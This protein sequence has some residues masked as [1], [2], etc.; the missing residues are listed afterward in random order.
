M[1]A[2]ARRN[3]GSS[4]PFRTRGQHRSELTIDTPAPRTRSPLKSPSRSEVVPRRAVRNG[5][6][7]RARSASAASQLDYPLIAVLATL[8]ALG[9]VMVYSASMVRA[10]ATFGQPAYF[11]VR[12]II[13]AGAGM[14]A[15]LVMSRIPYYLWQRMAIPVMAL[16]LLALV[17]V[18]IFGVER[19][20][21][22][23]TLLNGSL[24]PSEFV[25]LAI[26]IYVAAWVAS[27]KDRL[28]EVQ[29][30]LIPFAALMG[31]VVGL[32]VLE[33]SFSVSIIILAT[34]ITIFFVGGGNVKQ[35]MLT[36][37]IGAAVLA[38]LVWQSG[39]GAHRVQTWWATLA[40]PS[41]ASYDVSQAM[42]IIRE[43]RGIGTD[44]SNWMQKASVPL[45]WSDYLFANVGA[46][47]GFIGTLSVIVLFAAL[48]YR[49]LSIALNAPDQFAGLTAIGIT[50][51]MLTQALIHISA[52][53]A[54]IPTTGVPLPF[55]SYG[56]S[57][58]LA[59]MAALGMLL[60]ISRASPEKR[61][62]YA[63]FTFG[64]WHR[65]PHLP[66]SRGGQRPEELQR[67]SD[68]AASRG[69]ALRRRTW[70]H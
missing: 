65:R 57:S 40:D 39:Y 53:L 20:G 24:Q 14:G 61:A 51:W 28:V 27:K 17:S 25:K 64:W 13:W 16:A 59:N 19:Y 6:Q 52:S 68:R 29:G 3:T 1:N 58:M 36:G 9:L 10:Q 55:M 35:L 33:R 45:L 21:A 48:G 15:L 70:R 18:L 11:F 23:R 4:A 49:G 46:D 60:S 22:Q 2:V 43:G 32:I 26:V 44:S 31:I 12:Q 5:V 50:T 67:T 42:S 37:L 69:I 8:L 34:G 66:T 30:G 41:Q 7:G 56:G 62:P 54:L 47:L 38:L 63:D